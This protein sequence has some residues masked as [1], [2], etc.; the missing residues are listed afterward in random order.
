MIITIDAGTTNSRIYLIDAKTTEVI[1]MVK[2]HVGVKNTLI[3]GSVDVLKHELSSGIAE[4]TSRNQYSIKD[5]SY[6]V[7]AGMITSNLGLLEVPHIPSPCTI[8]DFSSASVVEVLPEFFNIP[9]IFIPGMKNSIPSDQQLSPSKELDRLDVMRGEEVETIGLIKQLDLK[10]KGILILPGSHTK[11]VLV[12]DHEVLSCLSTLSGEMLYALQKD[13][14]LSSSIGKELVEVTDQD[15][16]IQGFKA[17]Q[18]NGLARALY[19]IRLLQLFE[20]MDQNQRANF[21]VG[22]VLAS[23]IHS[24]EHLHKDLE[25]DW[26]LVGGVNPLRESFI[27]LLHYLGYLNVMEASDQQVKM[28][29]ILGAVE[30][31]NMKMNNAQLDSI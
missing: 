20:K 25:P 19:Q 11:Y 17:S 18:D 14:I 27:H 15:A 2:K 13:T 16:L 1:D 10:G 4:I 28:S 29:T 9:C 21:L 24:L 12:K 30:I 6:I 5:I 31:G 23:D 26:I 22:S 7:A 8:T 3:N